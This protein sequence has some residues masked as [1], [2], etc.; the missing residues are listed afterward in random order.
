MIKCFLSGGFIQV[1]KAVLSSSVGSIMFVFHSLIKSK[2]WSNQHTCIWGGKKNEIGLLWLQFAAIIENTE[3]N[4]S[5]C[6]LHINGSDQNKTQIKGFFSCL[7]AIFKLALCLH[8]WNAL[9][10]YLSVYTRF[11]IFT[12]CVCLLQFCCL[13]DADFAVSYFPNS[14][15]GTKL[16][17][18]NCVT[19]VSS[20]RVD[21]DSKQNNTKKDETAVNK[22]HLMVFVLFLVSAG[23]SPLSIRFPLT[24]CAHT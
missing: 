5:N 6:K 4:S 14:A 17:D 2:D 21:C 20:G 18:Y 9:F 13:V 10:S 12:W 1:Q 22:W 15:E 16:C 8:I 11:S 3:L 7:A 23:F 19:S 24:V